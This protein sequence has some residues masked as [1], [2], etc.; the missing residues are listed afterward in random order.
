M[1]KKHK[2]E[3]KALV[4]LSTMLNASLDFN[5]VLDSAM[6]Y[7]E[8]LMGAEASAIF[9]VDYERNELCFRLARGE[10]A[11]KAREVRLAMGEG[12]A[13]WV[14][15]EGKPLLVADVAQ[16]QRFSSRVDHHTGFR[17]RSVLC[18]PIKYKGR[19][20]GVLQVL[21]KREAEFDEEDL[22]I[23]TVVSNQVGIAMENARLYQ[24]LQE[25]FALSREELKRTEHKLIQSERLAA[26]GRLSQGVAHEVRNPVM[27][28]GGFAGRLK[29]K[30]SPEEPS[31][32]YV[33]II[34]EEVGRLEKMVHDIE[35]FTKLRTPEFKEVKLKSLIEQTVAEWQQ[36]EARQDIRTTLEL[37]GDE[38]TFPGDEWLLS[39]M[40]NNLLQNAGEAMTKGGELTISAMAEG[41]H[42]IVR[43]VDNG[44]GIPAEELHQVFDPFFTSKTQGTG[45][46]LTTVHRIVSEHNGEIKV[47]STPGETTEF[48][49]LLP[50][51]ADDIQLSEL[52]SRS[53]ESRE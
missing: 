42:I 51:F 34:L 29:Q 16:D 36:Q 52:E 5:E 23:L 24:R 48:R 17:T 15:E 38:I 45:L 39:I 53:K 11:K 6:R 43:V 46:G 21:N 47:E 49:I 50:L 1:F 20:I 32:K 30:I 44:K 14:A 25:K 19:L 26:L 12:I 27:S 33:D 13:G 31:Y 8:E 3:V 40:L 28:I 7:V 41:Q 10:E 4:E 35:A 2:D 37:P 22:E 18:V 9:E